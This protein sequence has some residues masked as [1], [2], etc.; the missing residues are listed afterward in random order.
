MLSYYVVLNV[1]MYDRRRILKVKERKGINLSF[2]CPLWLPIVP[3]S[4]NNCECNHT[5]WSN[6]QK[7]SKYWEGL[8]QRITI[9][10]CTQDF[11]KECS[12]MVRDLTYR[13]WFIKKY[14]REYCR[15]VTEFWFI[16]TNLPLFSSGV[17]SSYLL[18]TQMF[19]SDLRTKKKSEI[20]IVLQLQQIN[21]LFTLFCRNIH[22]KIP[23][24]YYM[25]G[26]FWKSF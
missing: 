18:Y 23:T 12:I 3:L 1:I 20:K 7:Y 14:I 15:T 4:D 11:L 6:K 19:F 17:V 9:N 13:H 21:F 25:P 24:V 8:T 5:S 10:S 2:H 16:I 22:L 26:W